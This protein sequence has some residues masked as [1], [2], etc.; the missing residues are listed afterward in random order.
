MACAGAIQAQLAPRN[1][2]DVWRLANRYMLPA[3]EKVAVEAALR[4][5]EELPPWSATGAQVLALVQADDL[6]AR[7]RKPSFSG[8][9]AVVGGRRAARGRAA[10]GGEARSR[11]LAFSHVGYIAHRLDP[12]P[13]PSPPSPPRELR[14]CM[15]P[16]VA[17][18]MRSG[19][20]WSSCFLWPGPL[21]CF[22]RRTNRGKGNKWVVASKI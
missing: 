10:R 3:L 14:D 8:S 18:W 11:P 16:R 6:V 5:F 21:A 20:S 13:P 15:P 4:G 7:A 2:L 9:C 19:Q 17:K 12:S 22:L 1:A